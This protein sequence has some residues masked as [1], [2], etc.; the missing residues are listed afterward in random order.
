MGSFKQPGFARQR[1]FSLQDQYAFATLSGDQN[2][3]HVDC[4]TARRLLFGEPVAHGVHLI[5]WSLEELFSGIQGLFRLERISAVFCKPARLGRCIR[6]DVRDSKVGRL[7]LVLHDEDEELLRLSLDFAQDRGQR[8][9]VRPA[10]H[11]FRRD[12]PAVPST[13]QLSGAVSLGCDGALLEAMFPQAARVLPLQQ[14]H[15]LLAAT[16][17][18]GMEAPGLN[19]LFTELDLS[20][21]S[22]P[23]GNSLS[24][25]T[26]RFDERFSLLTLTLSGPGFKGSARALIRPSPV[27]QPCVASLRKRVLPLEFSSQRALV[28]GGSRGLGEVAAKLLAIG[29]AATFLTYRHGRTDV[30]RSVN[31]ITGHGF[32]AAAGRFDCCDLDIADVET[33]RDWQPTHLYFFASP[34]IQTGQPSGFSQELFARFT[35]FYVKGLYDTV[36]AFSSTLQAIFCP[37]SIYVTTMPPKMVEYTT[38]KAAAEFLCHQLSQVGDR[39][40]LCSTPRLPRLETDQTARISNPDHADTAAVLLGALRD[41]CKS[42]ASA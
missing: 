17:V 37:S 41:F 1:R 15:A 35:A 23:V 21:Q 36:A 12:T 10:Y 27:L 3:I 16:Y 5:L 14:I 4:V 33:I 31:D 28:V 24:Y 19:S 42:E 13:F 6:L 40:L 26:S 30:D 18:V 8:E 11:S 39:P 29:G 9:I 38:A 2:P 20:F 7:K 22:N 25:S 34:F 32:S